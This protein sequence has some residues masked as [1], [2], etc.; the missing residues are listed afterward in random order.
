M[1]DSPLTSPASD[2][3]RPRSSRDFYELLVCPICF[4]YF[5]PPVVQCIRGHSFCMKC[6]KRMDEL[7]KTIRC[8]ICRG[9]ISIECRNHLIE[10]QLERITISC[11]WRHKG[12]DERITMKE[13]EH[14][15]KTCS[16]RPGS[17]LCYFGHKAH[18]NSCS[19]T[20]NP[21]TLP[22]HLQEAHSLSPIKRNLLV[23]FLWNPPKV[24]SPRSRYRVLKMSVPSGGR[25][26]SKFILEHFYVPEDKLALFLVRTVDC[27]L[28]VPYRITIPNREND[29]NKITFESQT[30][31]F[32]EVSH[33]GDWPKLD[34]K[35]MLCV[36]RDVLED[37]SC[38]C[39]DDEQ[40]Y[41]S[42]AIE[43]LLD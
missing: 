23:K 4:E 10:D 33:L 5:V 7:P 20:G 28:K 41:F 16:F 34:K 37:Y 21:C 43:F 40:Q 27:D 26:T 32:D 36:P 42:L 6:V 39:P 14:H 29:A 15:E 13:R 19:W 25:L 1:I 18:D 2:Q 31:T 35:A 38:T 12:C 17:T 3:K 8:P 30:A 24:L 22:R 11:V 9:E